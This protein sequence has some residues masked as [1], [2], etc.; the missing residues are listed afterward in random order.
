MASV[1]VVSISSPLDL[2]SVA[3]WEAAI[4]NGAERSRILVVDLTGC[5]FLDTAGVAMLFRL[6]QRFADKRY[7]V[8]FVSRP[9]SAADHV[10]RIVNAEARIP[11]VRSLHTAL[12][13]AENR[14][15][16]LSARPAATPA[17][18]SSGVHA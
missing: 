17:V 9:G 8:L 10:L 14:E 1:V 13:V 12:A 18:P 4:E 6:H 5:T 2:A 16:V 7:V 3:S 15:R 11:V